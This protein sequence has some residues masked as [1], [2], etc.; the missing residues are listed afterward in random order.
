MPF[1][2]DSSNMIPESMPKYYQQAMKVMQEKS[3]NRGCG[4]EGHDKLWMRVGRT[5]MQCIPCGLVF[6]AA[7]DNKFPARLRPT[8]FLHPTKPDMVE[9][10]EPEEEMFDIPADPQLTKMTFWS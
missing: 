6:P 10:V 4:R 3:S 1:T 8:V 9:A 7:R 5:S 2:S